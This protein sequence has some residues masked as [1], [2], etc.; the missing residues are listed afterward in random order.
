MLVLISCY[1]S[2]GFH[3]PEP[4]ASRAKAAGEGYSSSGVDGKAVVLVVYSG[5]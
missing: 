5:A 1:V 2:Q 4:M 3:I